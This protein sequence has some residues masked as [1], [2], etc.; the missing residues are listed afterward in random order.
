MH[1]L[2]LSVYE[3]HSLHQIS[4][5]PGLRDRP[6]RPAAGALRLPARFRLPRSLRRIS[7]VSTTPSTICARRCAACSNPATSST[8]NAAEARPTGREGKL[9]ELIDKADRPHGAGE[10]HLLCAAR[11]ARQQSANG[12]GRMADVQA[13]C[14]SR[15]PTRASTFSASRPCATCSARS[16]NQATAATTPATGPPA[17]KPAAHRGATSSATRSTW[18]PPPR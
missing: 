2:E 4:R 15:S 10:L 6:R 14:A 11:R 8:R 3:A 13:K 7:G 17:L 18:T 9:D 5:R 1:P 12:A 16:A